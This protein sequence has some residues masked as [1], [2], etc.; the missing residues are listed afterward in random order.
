[1]MQ[2]LPPRI[3][4]EPS[5]ATPLQ[6][7]A[8]LLSKLGSALVHAEELTEPGAH[9]FD[10]EA[11]KRLADDPEV[12]EWVE[13]MSALALLPVKRSEAAGGSGAAVAPA[14]RRARRQPRGEGA[15]DPRARAAQPASE[16]AADR[17]VGGAAG[18]APC[19]TLTHGRA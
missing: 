6:P 9:S 7:S 11:F 13:Q 1:M 10:L 4:H 12:I 17:V 15:A 2:A 18:G 14:D 3:L 19:L 5:A 16:P 8:S